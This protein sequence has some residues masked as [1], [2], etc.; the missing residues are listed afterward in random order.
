[1]LLFTGVV[2]ATVA[3]QRRNKTG[4]DVLDNLKQRFQCCLGRD[5]K[6]KPN[7][8][9]DDEN[10]IKEYF[11]MTSNA[12]TFETQHDDDSSKAPVSV[13]ASTAAETTS[14]ES[15]SVE[16]PADM[17][18]SVEKSVATPA[19]MPSSVEKSVATPAE[20]PVAT[21]VE[22]PSAVEK[23]V[24]TL[25]EMPSAVELTPVEI[26]VDDEGDKTPSTPKVEVDGLKT[27]S[28]QVVPASAT[29][30]TPSPGKKVY[31]QIA[32]QA[33]KACA[34]K[35]VETSNSTAIATKYPKGK[36]KK[37]EQAFRIASN[38]SAL[39]AKMSKKLKRLLKNDPWLLTARSSN[40]GSSCPD[41]YTLLMAAAYS[42]QL[43]AAEMILE[44][45]NS[46]NNKF[47]DMSLQFDRDNVGK[48]ALHIAAQHGHK[49]M[50]ELLLPL[51]MP[52]VGRAED[53]AP[54]LSPPPVDSMGRTPLGWAVTSQISKAKANKKWLE[55]KLYSP[56]DF[57]IQGQY[58]PPQDRTFLSPTLQVAYGTA[59][60]PGRRIDMEDAMCQETWQQVL[61]MNDGSSSTV[62]FTLL[63]V[64]DGHGD[65]GEVSEFVATNVVPIL[66]KNIENTSAGGSI[67]DMSSEEY[68]SNIWTATSIEV[69]AKLKLEKLDGGS[70]AC[71]ALISKD[72]IVVANTGDSRC[73]LVKEEDGVKPLSFDHK[74]EDKIETDRVTKAGMEVVRMEFDGEVFYKI[75]KSSGN[76]LSVSRAYGDFDYKTNN[77]L[78]PEAQAVTCVPDVVVHHREQDQ[79]QFL[80]LACD[81]IWDVMSNED[82]HDFVKNQVQMMNED[83]QEIDALLPEVGD[84]LLDECLRKGSLDNMT[85]IVVSLKPDA[86]PLLLAPKA[87]EF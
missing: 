82:V 65:G 40:M 23:P 1:M 53:G 7:A 76:T 6:A 48:C 85:A 15:T 69:D 14:V 42:G 81:G 73:I 62:D 37:V 8:F 80:V 36:G 2:A 13:T 35:V 25:V 63:G 9:C 75:K 86:E 84:A 47:S 49:E 59:E 20:K 67:V 46:S 24:E 26:P 71:F 39:T 64:C 45:L 54:I 29:F 5:E 57:S 44:A 41:S 3:A 38:K 32:S 66:R 60:K 11:K 70:T 83:A 51:T 30:Q 58:H 10:E 33:S 27:Q 43:E 68:W 4:N 52:V 18:S 56:Y 28:T 22:K 19:D 78:G 50:V 21:P 79:D 55:E 31:A 87:L 72:F 16:T 77:D 34:N 17:P 61:H 74:P 12:P